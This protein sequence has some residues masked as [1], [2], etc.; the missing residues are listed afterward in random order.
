MSLHFYDQRCLLGL[1]PTNLATA[2]SVAAIPKAAWQD[3]GVMPV[4]RNMR[5][6]VYEHPQL[7]LCMYVN[8]HLWSAEE[9]L[10]K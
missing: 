7:G 3:G 5:A 6:A 4:L 1:Q 2:P 9:L 10:L 8:E